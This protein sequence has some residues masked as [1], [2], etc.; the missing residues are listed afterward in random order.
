[1][2]GVRSINRRS[3]HRLQ[4]LRPETALPWRRFIA[5]N[6]ASASSAVGRGDD[7][8]APPAQKRL[9]VEQGK[10]VKSHKSLRRKSPRRLI[11]SSSVASCL[12]KQKRT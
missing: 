6:F 9:G 7:D 11:A 4:E 3:R 5:L 10:P 12:Q 8:P 2:E 1:M